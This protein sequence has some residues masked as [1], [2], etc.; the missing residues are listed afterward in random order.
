MSTQITINTIFDDFFV[1][2]F[3]SLRVFLSLPASFILESSVQIKVILN[4]YV[5]TSLW[6]LK[7]VLWRPS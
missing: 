6:Y 2:F 7:K 3:S 5:H 1:S 4:F